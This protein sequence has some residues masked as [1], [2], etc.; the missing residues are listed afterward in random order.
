MKNPKLI[1]FAILIVVLLAGNV[2]L[3]MQYVTLQKE[4]RESQNAVAVQKI[5]EKTLAFTQLFVEKVLKSETEV[6]FDTRLQLENAVRGIGD[7][8]ILSQWQ[9]FTESKTET[10]AQ[11]E[12]KNLL[13]LLMEKIEYKN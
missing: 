11:Q 3:G 4:L 1:L 7:E 9:R 12:V 6:D 10:E 5:N 2:F 13:S 8:E